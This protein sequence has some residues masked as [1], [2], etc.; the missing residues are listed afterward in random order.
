MK[1]ID[2]FL[3]TD[4]EYDASDIRIGSPMFWRAIQVIAV[5]M[6]V[7]VVVTEILQ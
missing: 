6:L 4:I 7:M 3:R 5:I 1:F 2:W